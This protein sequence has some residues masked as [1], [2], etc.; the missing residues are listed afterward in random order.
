MYDVNLEVLEQALCPSDAKLK[1][2]GIASVRSRVANL[3]EYLPEIPDIQA[4]QRALEAWLSNGYTDQE[5]VLSEEDKER[6]QQLA[7][8]KFAR[9]EWIYGHSP[10]ATRTHSARLVCGTVEVQL[11][12]AEGRI[13]SC[14]L[15]GDFLGNLPAGEVEAA[16]TGIPYEREAILE[17]LQTLNINQYFD[18][19]TAEDLIPLII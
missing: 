18:G 1:S 8:E 14:R 10:K 7:D 2:K 15:G 12:L 6:I 19:T 17:R 11:S 4:F 9:W 3:Q 16:L 13:A 5:Y